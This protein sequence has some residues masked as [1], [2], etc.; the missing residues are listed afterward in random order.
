MSES[1]KMESER[2][3]VLWKAKSKNGMEYLKGEVLGE[4]VVV[5]PTKEK[6][7]ESTPDYQV[8]KSVPTRTDK[9]KVDEDKQQ[10]KG[11]YND[12]NKDKRT[13]F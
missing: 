10:D 3:G 7:T 9:G 13:P 8:L 5:F 4:R 2:I 6:R 11:K 12:K 1:E